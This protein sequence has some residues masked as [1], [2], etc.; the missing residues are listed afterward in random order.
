MATKFCINC[1]NGLPAEAKFCS[2][3]GAPQAEQEAAPV[4]AE[5]AAMAN[6]PVQ[7]AVAAPVY[8]APVSAPAAPKKKKKMCKEKKSWIIKLIRNSLITAISL[9]MLIMAFLPIVSFD[10]KDS[11]DA[12]GMDSLLSKIDNDDEIYFNMNAFDF[13][14]ILFDTMKSYDEDDLY[15]SNLKDK[16]SDVMDELEDEIDY[17][18]EEIS[19]KGIRLLDKAFTLTLRYLCQSEE[20]SVTPAIVVLP[21]MAIVYILVAL[22]AFVLSVLNLLSCFAFGKKFADNRIFK[23][24]VSLIAIVPVVVYALFYVSTACFSPVGMSG[25]LVTML[26]MSV[27]AIALLIVYSIIFEKH[28]AKLKPV[29]RIV[30]CAVAAL[31]IGLT[32]APFANSNIKSEFKNT[33]SKKE[34]SISV[35]ANDFDS[36]IITESM[37]ESLESMVD[38]SKSETKNE[39]ES[40]FDYFSYFTTKQIKNGMADSVNLQL[41]MMLFATEGAYVILPIFTALPILN[42]LVLIFAGLILWQNIKYF[43]LREYSK[44]VVKTSKILAAVFAAIALALV[45]VF[46]AMLAY[47]TS[48][49]GPKNYSVSVGAGFIVMLVS[50]IAMVC[51]PFKFGNKTET[52]VYAYAAPVANEAAASAPVAEEASAQA[53][54]V[55][56]D[57]DSAPTD[58]DTQE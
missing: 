47:F 58:S 56:D 34:V 28:E 51:C 15:D 30:A 10:V 38:M 12:V 43:I 53:E 27:V 54:P 16:L 36:F 4:Q 14:A 50:V 49:Y 33:S 18:D 46:V 55:S 57:E 17:D 26:V 25:A 44:K 7:E 22:A 31:V 5:S 23:A 1:G 21:V 9:V 39:L 20:V 2:A 13:A 45:V 42:L 48:E 52:P 35:G 11:L 29:A 3:C 40:A 37:D 41:I 32:F 6:A 19:D 8:A 24:L